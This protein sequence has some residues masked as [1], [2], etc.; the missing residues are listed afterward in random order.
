MSFEHTLA[1]RFPSAVPMPQFVATSQV[2]LAH[3]GFVPANTLVCLGLCRDEACVPFADAVQTVWGP[4]FSFTSLAGNVLPGRTAFGAFLHHAPVIDGRQRIAL[5]G[6]NHIAID[7]AGVPG[8]CLRPG[9]PTP[10][11]ACGALV[12]FHRELEAGLGALDFDADDPEYSLLRRRLAT[13]LGPA[14]RPDLVDLTL[15]AQAV[16]AEDLERS[17]RVATDPGV[18]DVAVYTGIQIHGPGGSEWILRGEAY[19]LLAHGR[20][21]LA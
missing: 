12:G 1:S 3:Q 14:A 17:V 16:L 6:F 5:F 20:V 15:L 11:S 18:T 4:A 7:A 10:C 19:A 2:E 8:R 21:V 9:K 13:R